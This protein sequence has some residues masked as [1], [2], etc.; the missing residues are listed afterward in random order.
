MVPGYRQ[1]KI[2]EAEGDA[3][4][5]TQVAGEFAEYPFGR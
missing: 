3:A 5:F 4:R 2:D 1:R